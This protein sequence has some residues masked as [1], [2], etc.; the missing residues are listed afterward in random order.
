MVDRHCLE[1]ERGASLAKL[2]HVDAAQSILRLV[3]AAL[4]PTSERDRLWLL[5]A[6]ASAHAQLD[7]PE[8]ACRLARTALLGAARIHLAPV[9]Q[10]VRGLRSRLE[11][12]RRIPAVQELDERLRAL[13]PGPPQALP[14]T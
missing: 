11:G 8:E 6:L 13:V 2:G 3:L 14:S 5:T 1:G 7:E 12:H 9:I 10:L 4:G